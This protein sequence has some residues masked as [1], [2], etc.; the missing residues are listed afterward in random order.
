MDDVR[1]GGIKSLI[2]QAVRLGDIKSEDEPVLFDRKAMKAA[3]DNLP[4]EDKEV[5][6]RT[7][8]SCFVRCACASAP[9][10][11]RP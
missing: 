1:S 8:V 11:S 5:L 9:L 3:F 7:K 2:A 6:L 4:E 10:Y